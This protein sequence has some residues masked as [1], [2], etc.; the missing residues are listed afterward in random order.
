MIGCKT[1]GN[2]V[3]VF[4]EN[5][6]VAWLR[7]KS[8]ADGHLINFEPTSTLGK[9]EVIVDNEKCTRAGKKLVLDCKG[10]PGA[11]KKMTITIPSLAYYDLAKGQ[12]YDGDNE[13]EPVYLIPTESM[14]LVQR[15]VYEALS[16]QKIILS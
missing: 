4:L 10:E 9:L 11:I 5:N 3:F 6:D 12:E 13:Q 16:A 8:Q 14:S 2:D 7:Q 15:K 1:G